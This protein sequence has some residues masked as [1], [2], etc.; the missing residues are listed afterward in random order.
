M[1][2]AWE[3]SRQR[4]IEIAKQQGFVEK[5]C[6]CGGCDNKGYT[7]EDESDNQK[8]VKSLHE[9][10]DA[11]H[12]AGFHRNATEAYHCAQN[13]GLLFEPLA[14]EGQPATSVVQ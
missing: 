4:V 12:A 2:A 10:H 7:L 14:E 1:E 13:G 5:S 11:L 3:A 9:L 6:T 8:V